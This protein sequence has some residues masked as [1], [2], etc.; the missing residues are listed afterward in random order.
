VTAVCPN[1]HQSATTDYCDQCGARIDGGSERAQAATAPPPPPEPSPAEP[2]PA[3]PA[4][5]GQACPVCGAVRV[6][7]DR[8]CEGCG[9]DFTAIPAVGEAPASKPDT[10]WEAIV[11]ADRAYH[12][13]I[14]PEGIEF[15][16]HC[17]ARTFVID[18]AE[19]RIG[20][21]STARGV[22]PEIDLGGGPEDTAISHLH[23]LLV[24]RPDGSYALVDPGSTNG[25]T[26]NDVDTPIATNVAVPISEGDRIHIGAWTTITFHTR[27]AP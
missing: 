19:V 8:Y 12:E 14:A 10:V 26:V 6:G 23:A 25:T 22:Q 18:G 16:P 1:G 4:T 2:P 13:R 11:T 24:R 20:R 17:P 27:P 3:D 15:P 9:Y 7:A 21:R 5:A